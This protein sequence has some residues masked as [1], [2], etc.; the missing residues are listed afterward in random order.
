MLFSE[1]EAVYKEDT[2]RKAHQGYE[3]P[4][5]KFRKASSPANTLDQTL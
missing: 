1:P 5:L 2:A 4:F 3:K